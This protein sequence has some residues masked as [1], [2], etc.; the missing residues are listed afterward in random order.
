MFLGVSWLF[1]STSPLN[2]NPGPELPPEAGLAT[3]LPPSPGLSRSEGD[4]VLTTTPLTSPPALS[5]SYAH[6]L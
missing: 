6:D 4:G 2:P 3:S 1:L 5:P